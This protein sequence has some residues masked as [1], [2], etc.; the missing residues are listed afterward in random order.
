[1][2]GILGGRGVVC[3]ESP[4]ARNEAVDAVAATDELHKAAHLVPQSENICSGSPQ[5]TAISRQPGMRTREIIRPGHSKSQGRG[6]IVGMADVVRMIEMEAFRSRGAHQSP[7]NGVF[8]S[9][10]DLNTV[11]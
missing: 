9:Y 7:P 5:H 4:R 10:E 11:R 1:M 2:V 3:S 8:K 6:S